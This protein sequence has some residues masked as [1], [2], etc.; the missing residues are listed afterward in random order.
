MYLSMGC[1]VDDNGQTEQMRPTKY[2]VALS[3][4]GEQRSYVEEV[5]R[6]LEKR[7]IAV[8][9]DGFEKVRLWG[10]SGTEEFH[11]AFARQSAYVVMFISRAYVEKAWTRHERRSA[12]SL[13]I[14]EQD[15]YILPVRFDDTPVPG[16]PA[17]VIY[18][19]ASEHTP[20]QLSA[21]IADKLGIR[22]FDGK[23]SQIPP[24]RMT[25]PTGEVVFD[26][27]SHNGHYLIGSGE[28]AF[29]TMWT[30]ASDTSIHVYNVPPSI[31]GVSLARGCTSISQV[32]N[33]EAL[34]YTSCA[35]TAPLGG[36]VVLR[37]TQGFYAA[38][39]VLSIKDDTR[40]D[41]RDELRF[42]YAIQSD[43]SDSFAEF[44]DV[45]GDEPSPKK[46]DK[47]GIKVIRT[48]LAHLSETLS[49]VRKVKA[50]RLFS[51]V[52]GMAA[53]LRRLLDIMR[54]DPGREFTDDVATLAL[55][56]AAD[57]QKQA[58][59]QRIPPEGRVSP[60]AR[61]SWVSDEDLRREYAAIEAS[62][63]TWLPRKP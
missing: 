51:P 19:R 23:A 22:P 46:Q 38:V 63:T 18:Q 43:G 26:Y 21:M 14:H 10:R 57:A 44:V 31:Y 49:D 39:H 6:H 36:I 35:R 4:A 61:V 7:A 30:K 54:I 60:D 45:F 17:D 24:P 42:R 20:A 1:I 3:F 53:S 33:A 56:A 2:Q 41:D 34:D 16:L 52:G 8:F 47:E 12:L 29:E 48:R 28:L 27:S 5:A 15:E 62:L 37:N 59:D 32:L 11:E 13:M 9:Y 40:G 55:F 25:S 50:N 58:W